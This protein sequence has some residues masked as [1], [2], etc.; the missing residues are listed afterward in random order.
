MDQDL[1]VLNF[2]YKGVPDS[3]F[4]RFVVLSGGETAFSSN[5][6]GVPI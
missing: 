6:R 2:G 1:L 4:H 3:G 5:F